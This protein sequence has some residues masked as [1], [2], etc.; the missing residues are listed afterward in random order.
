MFAWVYNKTLDDGKDYW[1][2]GTGYDKDIYMHLDRF[3]DHVKEAF[4]LKN[5]NIVKKDTAA[6]F[7]LT[8]KTGFGWVKGTSS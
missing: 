8:M 6:A 2:I 3:F 5:V 7:H 1:V 4:Q